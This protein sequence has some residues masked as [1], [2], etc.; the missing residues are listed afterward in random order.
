MGKSIESIWN[1]GFLAHDALIAPKLNNLYTQKSIHLVDKFK[2]MYKI[3]IIAIFVFA[4]F[5]LPFT[6]FT[7]MPY[8]GIPMFIMF[9]VI[10]IIS[11]KLKKKLGEIDVSLNSYEYLNSF[12]E[13]V[14]EMVRINTKLSRY[15]YP[16]IFLSVFAGFWYGDFGGDIP[17][18]KL[19]S[20]LLIK[21]P[22]MY[23]IL[24]LPVIGILGLIL[25]IIILAYFGGRIGKWDLNLVYGGIL[26]R[27]ERLLSEMEELR[28]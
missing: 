24:G 28:R 3:N 20:W 10:A 6:Y 4:I 5:L 15:L 17:G 12:N 13:W 1:E 7:N 19:V 27:L 26:K 8:M 25:M 9:N 14:K 21:Y 16:Y 2:R 22:D 18:D 11:S 23:I